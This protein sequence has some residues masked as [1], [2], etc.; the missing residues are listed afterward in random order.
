[1][2][3]D[4]LSGEQTV[5]TYFGQSTQEVRFSLGLQS[6]S[7]LFFL[8]FGSLTGRASQTVGVETA[9]TEGSARFIG[10]QVMWHGL[11]LAY[12]RNA[13]SDPTLFLR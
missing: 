9:Q 10:T 2:G 5:G 13:P 12:G 8:P 3:L 6:R 1:M 11:D 7:L 4:K